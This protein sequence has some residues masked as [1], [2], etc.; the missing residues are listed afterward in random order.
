MKKKKLIPLILTSAACFLLSFAFIGVGGDKKSVDA[1]TT[2][3]DVSLSSFSMYEG[4]QIRLPVNSNG[5]T[6]ENG[7][8]RFM[9]LI[10]AEQ[11]KAFESKYGETAAA[12]TTEW[13]IVFTTRA[14]ADKYELNAANVFGYGGDRVYWWQADSQKTWETDSIGTT[15][16]AVNAITMFT[17]V[18]YDNLEALNRN[19]W[20]NLIN[21][22][23]SVDGQAGKAYY[24]ISG[25][26]QV[27]ES[28]YATEVVARAYVRYLN[29]KNTEDTSDDE[30]VYKFADYASGYMDNNSR[31]MTYVAQ[32]YLESDEDKAESEKVYVDDS[33]SQSSHGQNN[34]VSQYI[35][36][37]GTV[38]Y[39][40]EYHFTD[41]DGRSIVCPVEIE[42]S[43]KI[44]NT[45]IAMSAHE[46]IDMS[47]SND[48]AVLMKEYGSEIDWYNPYK[49]D[50]SKA[51]ANNRT[52]F[53]LYYANEF[54]SDS[55]GDEY[56]MLATMNKESDEGSVISWHSVAGSTAGHED[57]SDYQF[58]KAYT[59]GDD[60]YQLTVC[61]EH[62]AWMGGCKH[63]CESEYC[64]NPN[65]GHCSQKVT[66]Q[67]NNNTL[68]V[69]AT[70]WDD[71]LNDGAGDWDYMQFDEKGNWI[72]G[73]NFADYEYILLRFYSNIG[74]ISMSII[75]G[76]TMGNNGEELPV[77]TGANYEIKF[78]WNRIKID[79]AA[80]Q[81]VINAYAKSEGAIL[82][83]D[84]ANGELGIY[85]PY[86]NRQ[87]IQFLVND[88]DVYGNSQTPANPKTWE[89]YFEDVIGVKERVKRTSVQGFESTSLD[90]IGTGHLSAS[91]NT[92]KAFVTEGDS[93]LKLTAN[94]TEDADG[95]KTDWV[96]ARLPLQKDGVGLTL[97]QL[98]QAII[99]FDIYVPRQVT[100]WCCGTAW[101]DSAPL[102]ENAWNTIRMNG[103]RLVYGLETY[104]KASASSYFDTSTGRLLLEF[105]VSVD[106]N[107]LEGDTFYIDNLQATWITASTKEVA[108]DDFEARPGRTET[109]SIEKLTIVHNSWP[110]LTPVTSKSDISTQPLWEPV[111]DAA[112]YQYII[113]N[114]GI[115]RTDCLYINPSE[116]Y[117]NGYLCI[118][119]GLM[120]EGD[121][122]K[123]R[124]VKRDAKGNNLYG[125]WVTYVAATNNWTRVPD[126][127]DNVNRLM[128][129][130]VTISG[131]GVATWNAVAG[132]TNGYEYQINNAYTVVNGVA[133]E[134]VYSTTN[135]Y[136]RL[137]DGDS[138]S[139]RAKAVS[140]SNR[141]A[142]VWTKPVVYNAAAIGELYR[143]SIT[144]KDKDGNVIL[145]TETDKSVSIYDI[146]AV[147]GEVFLE[148]SRIP[149]PMSGGE[150]AWKFTKGAVNN[151][152]Y[153]M[154]PLTMG[155]QPLTTQQLRTIDY[156][157]LLVYADAKN[158]ASGT[159]QMGFNGYK[160]PINIVSEKLLPGQWN[161]IRISGMDLYMLT[162]RYVEAMEAS[163]ITSQ[164]KLAIINPYS[165]TI[166]N[167]NGKY[168]ERL[169]GYATFQL[170]NVSEGDS[171]IFDEAKIVYTQNTLSS[172]NASYWFT[173]HDFETMPI[174]VY[175]ALPPTAYYFQDSLDQ[176]A[177]QLQE[178]P[179]NTTVKAAY[180]SIKKFCDALTNQYG[181]GFTFTTSSGNTGYD[182]LI[183]MYVD[184]GVN[185]MMGLY[186]YANY[187]GRGHDYVLSMLEKCA[188]ND[189]AYLL[190]WMGAG[191][192]TEDLLESDEASI[193]REWIIEYATYGAMAG[194][195]MSDE[196][197]AVIFENL[198]TARE[199][200]AKYWGDEDMLYHG[201]LLP[202]WVGSDAWLNYKSDSLSQWVDTNYT[203]DDYLND[204]ISTYAPQVLSFDVYPTVS[205]GTMEVKLNS[206]DLSKNDHTNGTISVTKTYATEG[207][208]ALFLT[209]PAATYNPNGTL[210]AA[211]FANIGTGG[212]T[213]QQMNAYK[214]LAFD[215]YNP[216]AP[217]TISFLDSSNLVLPSG[218][219]TV[220]I[221]S[222][223]YDEI[224][225]N[226]GYIYLS[227]L[228]VE[229]IT[230]YIDNARGVIS[231]VPYLRQGY[232]KNLATIREEAIKANIPFWT[233]IQT[234]SF[235]GQRKPSEADLLWNVNTALAY[236]AKGIQYFNGVE[237]Y[238]E[239][240]T[241]DIVT[242]TFTGGL[243]NAN[244]APTDIYYYAQKANMYLQTIDHILMNSKNI[245][246]MYSGNLPQFYSVTNGV[247]TALDAATN[248][249]EIP[250]SGTIKHYGNDNSL[251]DNGGYG[252]CYYVDGNIM[253]GCFD[254]NG[255][256]AYYVVNN[257]VTNWGGANLL[258]TAARTGTI[259]GMSGSSAYIT[260]YQSG[261]AQNTNDL[262]SSIALSST[263]NGKAF[264]TDFGNKLLVQNLK[265]GEA[266]L[267]VMD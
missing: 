126:N 239:T 48:L 86:R 19:Q 260:N 127:A 30:Y 220:K 225:G 262:T 253:V 198:K 47:G 118:P 140:S 213:L 157:E 194:I 216:G 105:G 158:T 256:T 8:L 33:V 133:V 113:N 261:T 183:E 26:V 9:A 175:N 100:V 160:E 114:D 163:D 110:A 37:N 249:A 251:G 39:T 228:T 125:D 52:V 14:K 252:G 120:R 238:P 81:K 75:A 67:L 29:D 244:G 49:I 165:N 168:L 242:R 241:N 176:L 98:S 221:P 92:D 181:D 207:K 203:Y 180:D 248:A 121:T 246:V 250:T 206:C 267:V 4:S 143:E 257:S 170:I 236:G 79:G 35:D 93:S 90:Q 264:A 214:H 232:Y 217:V 106:A 135:P 263:V 218:W 169:C 233:Y 184:C 68:L 46:I 173:Q 119:S 25:A 174:T 197:G 70:L 11:Y 130:T 16:P 151:N 58:D 185:T 53:R 85:A 50:V 224:A 235:E 208:E 153:L 230:I 161:S 21:Q 159:L 38:G 115:I 117:P 84:E 231:D 1:E 190:A 209:L 69:N 74:G 41:A 134:T 192:Q 62:E 104:A 191:T 243:F 72:G 111:A 40:I 122:L 237:P 43:D 7:S 77:T 142:S 32:K 66:T 150:Y 116:T 131:T 223:L 138:I 204:Y 103:W 44:I 177:S 211:Y 83:D 162:Q 129:P 132:A 87:Y 219:S 56:D 13:G 57:L 146:A 91:I 12:D 145:T 144:Y 20:G 148:A 137:K 17:P 64:D 201:N 123:I 166:N 245:G 156:I 108:L 210:A 202:N 128:A 149:S 136:V 88:D 101:S 212:L 28:A 31:S 266:F 164:Q 171:W 5:T 6:Y 65:H 51:Y 73:L 205:S 97:S 27:P 247:C 187:S 2:A 141:E 22:N 254:Y 99:T 222:S 78:G 200:F 45:E 71:T 60:Y 234:S 34:Q 82:V 265:P 229:Q 226:S 23:L 76:S 42:N 196:P 124:V 112:G 95:K 24:V 167:Y 259:Y 199:S 215:V 172:T 107:F 258:F 89:L 152:G 155:G 193:M 178:D 59:L 61:P 63:F 15:K 154:L 189:L 188:E 139:V 54:Y 109:N 96:S 195:M 240:N 18:R 55:I 10:D 186:D 147:D 102:K 36:A 94:V 179:N 255:K 182:A 227:N 80:Y 3:T